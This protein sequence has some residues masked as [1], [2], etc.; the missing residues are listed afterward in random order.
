[1]TRER[2]KPSRRLQDRALD[3]LLKDTGGERRSP[4][5]AGRRYEKRMRDARRV[6]KGGCAVTALTGAAAALATALRAR[7]WL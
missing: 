7:G 5:E 4:V 2:R 6:K 3:K 1:M